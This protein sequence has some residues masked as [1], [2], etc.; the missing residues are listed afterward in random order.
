MWAQG[1]AVGALLLPPVAARRLAVSTQLCASAGARYAHAVSSVCRLLAFAM[2][3][4]LG[5]DVWD[6]ARQLPEPAAYHLGSTL[7][8]LLCSAAAPLA[9]LARR[10]LHARLQFAAARGDLAAVAGL[11]RWRQR[12]LL[13]PLQWGLVAVMACYLSL[14]AAT[15]LSSTAV[16]SERAPT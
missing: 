8:Q 16:L 6:M 2:P 1:A 14:L 15:Y 7:A 5:A 13:S 12:W 4:M 10:E 11:Q 9:V 3:P